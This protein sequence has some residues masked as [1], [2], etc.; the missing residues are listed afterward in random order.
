MD[1]ICSF[2]HH[3]PRQNGRRPCHQRASPRLRRGGNG[4]A[5]GLQRLS[6][7]QGPESCERCQAIR[8]AA[9][10]AALH[11]QVRGRRAPGGCGAR[12]AGRYLRSLA[13][14]SPTAAIPIGAIPSAVT[15]LK[16]KGIHFIDAGTSGGPG[17]ALDGARFMVGGEDAA[18]AMGRADFAQ[19]SSG[20]GRLRPCRW[21][22]RRSFHQTGAQRHRI[23]NV[24]GDCCEGRQPARELSG[25]AADCR[26]SGPLAAWFGHSLLAGRSDGDA[27]YREQGGLEKILAYVDDT[28]E[29]NWLVDDV[30]C[31]WK[32]LSRRSPNRS[33]G[34]S[35]R[36]TAGAMLGAR[37]R[38]DAPR[39]RRSSLMARTPVSR[40]EGHS[41]RVGGFVWQR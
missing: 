16:E 32:F 34:L 10:V 27:M 8:R 35:P 29:V 15:R 23:R 17:G 26:R 18:V 7:G 25:A 33:S 38:H 4:Y 39:F 2:Q 13:T 31:T 30:H 36:V 5:R 41:W 9:D 24:A 11:Q 22:W 3:R 37:H 40:I 1:P 6:D 12:G 21:S 14:S 19:A 20:R 28:G